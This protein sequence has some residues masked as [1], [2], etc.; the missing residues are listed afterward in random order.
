MPHIEWIGNWLTF[1]DCI[2]DGRRA[3]LCLAPGARRRADWGKCAGGVKTIWRSL[4]LF[5]GAAAV[6]L[7]V[8]ALVMYYY[9]I[10]RIIAP[11]LPVIF[12]TDR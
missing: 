3:W 12:G 5:I 1:Q 9:V 8:T 11:D 2:R 4:V 6:L 10:N 7:Q